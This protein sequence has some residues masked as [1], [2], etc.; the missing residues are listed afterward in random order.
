[1]PQILKDQPER[2]QPYLFHGLDL[3]WKDGDKYAN[4]DCPFCG[5]ERHFG[6]EIETGIWK[7]LV[8]GEGSAKGNGNVYTFL[9]LLWEYSDKNTHD[10]SELQ[11]SRRLM[12][13]DTLMR[14]GVCQSMLFGDWLVP[15][16]NTEGKL[17][18]LYRYLRI[19]GKGRLLPTP[20]LKHQLHGTIDQ[21][22]SEVYICEGPWDAMALEEVLSQCKQTKEG[23]RPTAD[24]KRSLMNNCS[25]VA[26]PGCGS[27]GVPFE[28][29]LP[30]F[31]NKQIKLMFDSDHPRRN[32]KTGSLSQ[33][34]GYA[35]MMRAADMLSS[36]KEPPEAIEYLFWGKEGYD[37]ALPSGYDVRDALSLGQEGTKPVLMGL[38]ERIER[39]SGVLG[40]LAAYESKSLDGH[41]RSKKKGKG[42]GKDLECSACT[43]YKDLVLSWRKAMKWTPG[44]D[45]ALA[46]MLACVASTKL[47]GDQCWLKVISPA[48]SGKSTLAEAVSVSK[49][50]ITAKSTIR[51]FHSGF[52]DDGSER[53]DNSLLISLYDKTLIIKD[54]DTLLQSP[55]LPQIL[56]EARDIYDGVSRTSYRNKMSKD[57]EGIRLTII[58]CGTASLRAIDSSELGERFLDVV[59]MDRIDD[60]LEDEVLS[61]VAHRADRNM[62]TESNGEA[63][64][65]YEPELAAAM[66]LTGGYVEY[67][68]QNAADVIASIDMSTEAKHL[69]TRLGKFTAHMRARPSRHQEENAEREFASRLVSQLV[70][71]AKCL[72]LVTNQNTVNETV[73]ARVRQVALD[74]SR[75]QTMDIVNYL[76]S[77]RP[78]GLTKGSIAAKTGQPE[79]KTSELLRFLRSIGV[80]ENYTS[81]SKGT[82][83]HQK[84]R[85]TQRMVRMYR[86]AVVGKELIDVKV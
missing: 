37:P 71:L 67:L 26:M 50:Y 19:N 15:G 39:L 4:S 24:V 44:L 3:H 16:Y 62:S 58:L 27:I 20:T 52:K 82:R 7:C 54:G 23:L 80:A 75:G 42:E 33:P 28:K 57:Y 1:M 61:R 31:S 86:E 12:N 81:E 74:T 40:K 25:V 76:W 48:A 43:K 34:A 79:V 46:A 55:N 78:E 83:G 60:E 65:R 51:G 64:S 72:A 70:R 9:R 30:L 69:C 22:K 5:K 11:S 66:Q 2:L 47:I 35:A 63:V 49:K 45:H 32:P 53:E 10:Y 6:I 85:L 14:W 29:F 13:P 84:W 68:R 73:M 38:E 21:T 17:T 36:M 56:S 18:Q 77:N 41:E 59:I 8:C